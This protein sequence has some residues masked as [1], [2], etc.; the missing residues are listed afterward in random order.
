MSWAAEEFATIDLA[1]ARL[2][3]RAV[4]LA[5]RLGHKPG[6]SIPNA[7]AGWTETAAAYRFRS[8]QNASGTQVL[9][10]HEHAACARMREHEVVLCLQDTT[11][12]PRSMHR[13]ASSRF[14]GG[15]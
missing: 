2:D 10:A 11:E 14:S 4:L 6:Q 3:R 5:E 1:D 12:L 13:L 9:Q 7:C 15:C 8:N